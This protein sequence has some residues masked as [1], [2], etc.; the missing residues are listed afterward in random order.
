MDVYLYCGF[1]DYYAAER[2]FGQLV[3]EYPG[4]S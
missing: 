1:K 4:Q 2:Y 3:E